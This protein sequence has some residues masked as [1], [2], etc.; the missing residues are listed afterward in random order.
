M[1]C[2]VV[3]NFS[4]QIED[5]RYRSSSLFSQIKMHPSTE[6]HKYTSF[7]SNVINLIQGNTNIIIK[8]KL[9]T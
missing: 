8:D 3:V 4:E 9:K 2:N 7:D 1:Y 5:N 6:N